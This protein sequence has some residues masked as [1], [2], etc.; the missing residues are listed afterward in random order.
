MSCQ[1]QWD[2]YRKLQWQAFFG[3][4]G[5]SYLGRFPSD[6]TMLIYK[7]T[8]HSM[9]QIV[10]YTLL[11]ISAVVAFSLLIFTW[12]RYGNFPCPQ[13]RKRFFASGSKGLVSRYETNPFIRECR[14]CGLKKWQCPE[15]PADDS[16]G[17]GIII[18]PRH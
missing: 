9:P 5:G 3:W 7:T 14:N 16:D 13:C 10:F 18:R 1:E 12:T 17:G 8:G 4:L 2:R 15:E 11:A 6:L